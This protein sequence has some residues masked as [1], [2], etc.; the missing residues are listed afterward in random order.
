MEEI[1]K[2]LGARTRWERDCII[3]DSRGIDEFAVPEDLMSEMR[4][5]VFLMGSLLARCGEALIH[6]PG[7]CNIGKRPIDIHVEGLGSSWGLKWKPRKNGYGARVLAA[8]ER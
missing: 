3:V 8:E 1:L 6:R 5:S 2:A 7:G 4:S